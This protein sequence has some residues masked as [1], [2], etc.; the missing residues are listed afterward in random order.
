MKNARF[1]AISALGLFATSAFAH[2]KACCAGMAGN[3]SK[4][5]CSATFAN[6]D[7]TAAQKAKMEKLAARCEK[8]GC[9]EA[10]MAQMEKGAKGVL[11]K[12]QFAAWKAACSSKHSEKT[13]G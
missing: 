4:E 10:T 5:A 1:F 6:L 3:E 9:D 7:L 11:T 2:D 12:E 8:G 13:Q